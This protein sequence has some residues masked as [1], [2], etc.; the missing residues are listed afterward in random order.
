MFTAAGES[1]Y[2][3]TVQLINGIFLHALSVS[4]FPQ[5]TIFVMFQAELGEL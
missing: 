5:D 2:S 1:V 3:R 4:S